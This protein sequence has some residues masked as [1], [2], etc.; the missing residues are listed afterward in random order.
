MTSKGASFRQRRVS[1]ELRALRRARGLSCA[2][3]A[4]AIGCSESKISRMETGQ[5]GL[6]VDEVAAILGYLQAPAAL[7]HELV[8]LVRDGEGRNWHAVHGKLPGHWK[9]LIT[10]EAEA[11]ALYNFEPMV[12]PG[13][14]QTPDYARAIIAGGTYN[15]T[16]GELDNLVATRMGR[17]FV[18][19]R[20]HVHLIIDE[21]ALR[22]PLGDRQMMHAQLRHL[23]ALT[24]RPNM[25]IL[26]V[27]FDSIAHPG[28]SGAF[29][30]LEFNDQ[31]GL[32]YVEGR[33]TSAFLEEEVHL[34]HARL[35]WHKLR[36]LALSPEQSVGLI[37]KIAGEMSEP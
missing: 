13:L 33:G 16:V 5:R 15:L 37:A 29:V 22:R 31:P 14:T 4:K 30:R 7:R 36:D 24:S 19:G 8:A 6:Q 34:E 2:E 20:A 1:T 11:S 32:V 26:I 12:M 10:I 18:L 35:A 25:E 9:D 27:P 23:M 3:V 28:L 21:I 17:Q